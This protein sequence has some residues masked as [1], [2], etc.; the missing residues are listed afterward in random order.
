MYI[1]PSDV[2]KRDDLCGPSVITGAL[3]SRRQAEKEGGETRQRDHQKESKSG[4][5]CM[6]LCQLWGT[7]VQVRQGGFQNKGG[8]FQDVAVPVLQGPRFCKQST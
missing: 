1:Y 7:R 3:S 2:L 4:E 8:F 6:C 5:S